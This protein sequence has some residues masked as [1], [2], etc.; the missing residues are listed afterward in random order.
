MKPKSC[1]FKEI[2]AILVIKIVI[3]VL[4]GFTVFGAAYR[5]QVDAP[6]MS[7]HILSH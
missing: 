1:L 5:L 2:T 6:L 4:A 3:I 7:A